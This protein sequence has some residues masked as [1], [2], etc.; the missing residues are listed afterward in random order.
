MERGTRL[1][2]YEVGEKIGRGGMGEVYRARDT[3]LGRE[4]ALKLLPPEF[5]ADGER[6]ARFEREAKVLASLHHPNIASIF[7]FENV[8]GTIF[9]VMEFVDGEDLAEVL[10]KGPLPVDEAVD[11][12]RQI[13]EGLEEAHE[14]GIVHR[15]LKPA[16]VKRTPDGKVKVLDFGLAR[17]FAGQSSGEEVI[18]SAPTMTAAMTQVG[19]VLGTA[20]YMS[21]EQARGREVDRRADIWAFGVILFEMLTGKQTFVGET[22]SDTLAGILKSDPEWSALPP[23]LPFQV[24]RV[25]RRCLEKDPRQRLR[26]IGE[27]RVRLE[28][29]AAESGMFTQ[30]M[31]TVAAT[32]G[33]RGGP[34]RIVPWVLVAVFAAVAAWFALGGRGGGDDATGPLHLALPAPD[35]ANFHVTGSFPGLPEISPDGTMVAFSA[36]DAENNT[37]DLYLRSLDQPRAI[38]LSDTRDAQYPFWSPDSRWIAYYDRNTGLMKIPVDG[39]PPQ[40]ICDAGNGKGGSWNRQGEILLT[41]DYNTSIRLVPAAGGEARAVT[42][43]AADREFNSHR[44]PQFMPDG[45]HFIYFA[46]AGGNRDS[47]IRFAS[48]DGDSTQVVTHARVMGTWASGRL[49]YER[50]GNLVAQPMDPRTGRLSGSPQIVVDD[51]MIINGAARAAY[52]ISSEGSLCYLRGS[53]EQL[54][55]LNWI[56]RDG[57]VA[58]PAAEDDNYAIVA[59]SPDGRYLAANTTIDQ[60]GTWDIWLID[61]ERGLRSRFTTHPA[62]DLDTAWSRDGRRLYFI[63]DRSGHYSVYRKEVGSPDAPVPV[64]ESG[65]DVRLLDVSADERTLILAIA[66]EK[67]QFDLWAVD[68]DDPDHPRVV[69][70]TPGTELGAALSPD[71]KWFVFSSDESGTAQSYLAPWPAMAPLV[72]LSVKSGTRVAWTKGGR[73]VVYQQINGTLTAVAV[74]I[75]DGRPRIGRP[76]EL[77]VIG[78]PDMDACNWSVS[79]DGERFVVIDAKETAVPR[80]VNLVLGWPEILRPE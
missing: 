19:T 31:A 7:G 53:A 38:R 32:P 22:A 68:L 47:E 26:D 60:I 21:P 70:Q 25:L 67:T 44:H 36:L 51:V 37:V 10:R 74:D 40:K 15:D 16:N 35:G 39:G 23:K 13:A 41:T 4:V 55:S 61:L 20:A 48:L 76:Q 59:L 8:A 64:Y 6:L 29:P 80:H 28:D 54:S 69:R 73:E 56:G 45:R 75:V 71:E 42:D 33:G 27:A 79:A 66:G 52:S 3:K 50:N 57:V 63:S 12:A 1:A 78:P 43:L 24:E 9:L 72:Q 77:F 30:A 58:E 65:Q 49:V 5:A 62:D 14:K 18:S 17:A 34:A 2:H 11:V 46:R